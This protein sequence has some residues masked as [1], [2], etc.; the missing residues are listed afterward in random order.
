M[1]KV[2][3]SAAPVYPQNKKYVSSNLYSAKIPQENQ[4]ALEKSARGQDKQTENNKF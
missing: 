4:G 1:K 2:T 3:F